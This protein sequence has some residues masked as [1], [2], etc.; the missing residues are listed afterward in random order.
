YAAAAAAMVLAS[1]T[2]KNEPTKTEANDGAIAFS[3]YVGTQSR[4]TVNHLAEI[5]TAGFGVFA[6]DQGKAAYTTYSSNS[7]YPN[8]MFNHI[9][10]S[11]LT[12]LSSILTTTRVL[13]I[14]SL[15]TLLMIQQ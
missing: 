12:I 11:G 3:A 10:L 2:P 15:H 5:Q 14:L 8:F 1:C 6:Y 13:S 9:A 7:S 4:A